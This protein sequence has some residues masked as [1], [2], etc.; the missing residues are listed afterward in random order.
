MPVESQRRQL[1][2]VKTHKSNKKTSSN[3]KNDFVSEGRKKG[4]DSK[5]I[6]KKKRANSSEDES[7]GSS[8]GSGGGGGGG[9]SGGTSAGASGSGSGGSGGGGGS[10]SG[11]GT[12][13]SKNRKQKVNQEKEVRK[14]QKVISFGFIHKNVFPIFELFSLNFLLLSSFLF[15]I[16]FGLYGFIYFV[17]HF[18][19][20]F[21]L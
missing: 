4:K 14:G 1:G 5:S 20:H 12:I 18:V 10:G 6:A 16:C 19:Y 2:K 13:S 9:G 8:G 7:K 15:I 17:V 11:S 21:I 3:H